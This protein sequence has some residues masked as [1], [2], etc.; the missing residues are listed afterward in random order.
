LPSFPRSKVGLNP[1]KTE[2]NFNAELF[3]PIQ[4]LPF[5][6]IPRRFHRQIQYGAPLIDIK[7]GLNSPT[8]DFH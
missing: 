3:T 1:N 7:N 2:K 8:E 6:S 4:D 5:L